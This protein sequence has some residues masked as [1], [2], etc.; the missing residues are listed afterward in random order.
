M[1]KGC[2]FGIHQSS[3]ACEEVVNLSFHTQKDMKGKMEGVSWKRREGAVSYE[4]RQ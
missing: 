1:S 4:K 2:H 3:L